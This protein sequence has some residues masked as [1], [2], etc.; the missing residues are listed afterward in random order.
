MNVNGVA[1]FRNIVGTFIRQIAAGVLGLLSAAAVARLYGPAGNGEVAVALLLALSLST[2][3]S[4]GVAAANVYYLGSGKISLRDVFNANLKI[5]IALS[6]SG[7]AIGCGVILFLGDLIFSEMPVQ[8]LWIAL[9]LFPLVLVNGFVVSF[10]QGMQEFRIYNRL[11]LLQPGLLLIGLLVLWGVGARNAE[12]AIIL[13]VLSN[14]VLLLIAGWV[15][16]K[17][18]RANSSVSKLN[19]VS[20]TLKYGWKAHLSN[21]L[22][23]LNYKADVFL[24]SFFLGPAAT[25]VY[26]VAVALGEKLWLI[27]QAVSTVLLPKL[28]QLSTEEEARKRLTPMVTRWVFVV[29]LLGGL[30][31]AALSEWIVVGV[32]GDNFEAAV[33]VLWILLPGLILASASRVLANDIAARGRPEL[34]T[35]TALVVLALNISGNVLLI[36][37]YGLEGAAAATTIAY[38][39]NLVLRLKIYKDLS[40]NLWLDPI[41][42]RLTD[43]GAVRK[44]L[45]RKN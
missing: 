20:L 5:S 16:R 28:S 2:F 21:I 40:G 15:L 13:H 35:Y 41:F 11:A 38:S 42:P 7:V 10:F 24:T 31:L 27:S 26:V 3:L 32:F 43:L 29:T 39:F 14:G 19:A 23:F 12:D 8:T 22:A 9:A 30:F 4:F 25:G 37:V 33:R 36:P 1:L 34:N 44:V 17:Y 6:V 18:L 45:G